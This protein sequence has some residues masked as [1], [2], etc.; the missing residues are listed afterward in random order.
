VR[1]GAAGPPQVEDGIGGS[2]RLVD[3]PLA[4]LVIADP[5]DRDA[6]RRQH[7]RPQRL[8]E[9]QGLHVRE[10]RA[11]VDG[12]RGGVHREFHRE[13]AAHRLQQ[14][15]GLVAHP[16]LPRD[17]EVGPGF[18]QPAGRQQLATLRDL[19]GVGQRV[20]TRH[21]GSVPRREAGHPT[22]VEPRGRLRPERDDLGEAPGHRGREGAGVA[23]VQAP[24]VHR[25]ARQLG[26]AVA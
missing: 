3:R 7:P 14:R 11:V 25:V 16:R 5:R 13:R 1:G 6:A 20:Q 19:R 22:P 15:A 23:A 26:G 9:R 17:V 18:E 10:T 4:E 24:P 12:H 2:G 8:F 21:R